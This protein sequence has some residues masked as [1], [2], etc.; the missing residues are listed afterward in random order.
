[1][2]EQEQKERYLFWAKHVLPLEVEGHRRRAKD[3]RR[4]HFHRTIVVIALYSL[5]TAAFLRAFL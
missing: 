5:L 2:T 4:V 1:M 3:V